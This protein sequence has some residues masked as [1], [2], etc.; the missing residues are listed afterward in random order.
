MAEN[1]ATSF[2]IQYAANTPVY[3]GGPGVFMTQSGGP[4]I[5]AHTPASY[6]TALV[7]QWMNSPG[8]RQNILSQNIFLGVGVSFYSDK[9]FNG[10]MTGKAVQVFGSN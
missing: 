3:T 4:E 8:H 10:M 1:I 5:P 7:K 2:G 6:A 9:S